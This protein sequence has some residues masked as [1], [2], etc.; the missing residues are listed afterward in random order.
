MKSYISASGG[1]TQLGNR[2]NIIVQYPN[3]NVKSKK[4][5]FNPIVKEGCTIIVNPKIPKEPLNIN[6]FL[7]DTASIIASL[8]LIYTVTTN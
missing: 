4:F 2:N 3:G 7:R 6:E 1:V 8:A 5:L